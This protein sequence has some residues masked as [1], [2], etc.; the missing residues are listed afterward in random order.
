[1]GVAAVE[2]AIVANLFFLVLLA[3]MEFARLNM[4]RNLSQDAAYYAARQVIVPGATAGEAIDEANRIM[5]SLLNNGYTVEV[6][7]LGKGATEVSVTDSVDLHKVALF[8]PY[9]LPDT[10]MRTVAHMR[11]ERYDGFF[12][13]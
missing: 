7:D 6:T 2:F 9:F 5:S 8:T 3:C 4:V 1:M 11:T 10:T 13:Q 12:Q